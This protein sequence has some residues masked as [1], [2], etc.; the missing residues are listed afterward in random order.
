MNNKLSFSP[1]LRPPRTERS[2]AA[3]V[4]FALLCLAHPPRACA[5][6]APAWMHAL[7]SAPLPPHDEKAEAVLLYSEQI[8]V[9]QPNGKIKKIERSAYKILRP[10]GKGFGKLILLFDGETRITTLHG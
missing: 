5:G 7:T 2:L 6:D 10:G 9:V 1:A 8:L 3:A 4:F